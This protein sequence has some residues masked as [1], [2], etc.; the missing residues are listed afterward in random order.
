MRAWLRA[1]GRRPWLR[2]S[3]RQFS[4]QRELTAKKRSTLRGKAISDSLFGEGVGES[5]RP[6]L[7]P[8]AG[9]PVSFDRRPVRP[10]LLKWRRKHSL[11][12]E[13]P[14]EWRAG[15]ISRPA[16]QA[17][18]VRG[19][20]PAG[21]CRVSQQDVTAA[22]RSKSFAWLRHP[23]RRLVLPKPGSQVTTG[24]DACLPSQPRRLCSSSFP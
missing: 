19:R 11:R 5:A 2:A 4:G 15:R 20:M 6:V 3:G 16:G 13:L 9:R 21:G 24:V 23:G 10:N 17:R 14:I 12:L 22:S 18:Q 8:L 1:S 7:D